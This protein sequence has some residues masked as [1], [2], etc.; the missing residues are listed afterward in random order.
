VK[1]RASRILGAQ[2]DGLGTLSSS[3]RSWTRAVLA[4]HVSP[5]AA[6]QRGNRART[7]GRGASVLGP[8]AKESDVE[9]PSTRRIRGHAIV[10][11]DNMQRGISN[12]AHAAALSNL[13]IET[14]WA[15]RSERVSGLTEDISLGSREPMRALWPVA[16]SPRMRIHVA[17]VQRAMGRKGGEGATPGPAARRAWPDDSERAFVSAHLGK[18]HGRR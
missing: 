12:I 14:R 4:G 5:Q 1:T 6:K 3:E 8:K 13:T 18:R 9:T 2:I 11:S 17:P 15:K 16:D 7:A 10:A